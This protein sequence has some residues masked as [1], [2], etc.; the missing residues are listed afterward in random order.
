MLISDR[1]AADRAQATYPDGTREA[2]RFDFVSIIFQ[3]RDGREVLAVDNVDLRIMQKE[4]VAL[5]GPSG[6]GK[7][8]LLRSVAGLVNPS[9]G[10]VRVNANDG[11]TGF[12]RVAVVFQAATL[13]PWKTVLGNLLYPVKFGTRK[14]G[15]DYMERARELLAMVGLERFADAYPSELSGGMQQRVAICRALILDPD[16]LLMDEPFSALDALTREELQFELRRI[17]QTTGKTILFVTHSMSES[18]LLA[19]RIVVMAAHPGRIKDDFRVDL[20]AQRDAST[21]DLPEFATHVKRVRDGIY[22]ETR[23]VKR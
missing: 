8:T 17:H 21:L 18:V 22:G 5:V 14:P 10:D 13:L 23:G 20:P 1:K 19:D 2:V 7:S 15:V 12:A 4:F 16:I 9:K 6:C 3:A 11:L